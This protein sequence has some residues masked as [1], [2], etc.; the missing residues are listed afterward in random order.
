LLAVAVLRVLISIKA[1]RRRCP[2]HSPAAA[3]RWR[4]IGRPW[5]KPLAWSVVR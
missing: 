3:D 2:T 5:G 4:C 1:A